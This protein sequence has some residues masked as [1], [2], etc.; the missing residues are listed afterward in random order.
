MLF[1]F[2]LKAVVLAWYICVYVDGFCNESRGLIC[3]NKQKTQFRL[4]IFN[5]TSSKTICLD[6]SFIFFVLYLKMHAQVKI[7]VSL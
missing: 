1:G 2:F 3:K 6:K 4:N 5:N 7:R